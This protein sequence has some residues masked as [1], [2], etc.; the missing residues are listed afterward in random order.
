MTLFFGSFLALFL[1][2]SS[3]FYSGNVSALSDKSVTY[4]TSSHSDYLCWGSSCSGYNYLLVDLSDR[5]SGWVSIAY[6]YNGSTSTFSFPLLSSTSTALIVLNGSLLTDFHYNS[7]TIVGSATFTLSENNPFS[8]GVIPSGTLSLT[9]NG[10][11][12]VSSYEYVDV[13]VPVG[14]YSD[15]IDEIKHAILIIPAVLI[16]IYVFYCIYRIIIINTRR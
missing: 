4:S 10:I 9:D 13:N 2:F 14:D 1:S 7:G 8:N 11:Y 12:D 16:M 3:L 5:V 15:E 6:T